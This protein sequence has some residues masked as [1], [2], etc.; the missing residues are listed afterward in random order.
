VPLLK[1]G[2]IF[3]EIHWATLVLELIILIIGISVGLQV[4]EWES[5]RKDRL[6][7]TEYMERLQ[8]DFSES[9][10]ALQKEIENLSASIDKMSVGTNLLHKQSLTKQ[11]HLQ[12]FEAAAAS[13]LV[14][15]FGVLFGTVEELKD[16]GNMRLLHSKA[17]RIAL[18]NL[19]QNYQQTIRLTEMRNLLRSQS[20]P[21]LTRQLKPSEENG[22]GWDEEM[23][24]RQ[25]REIYVALSILLANQ[26][27]DLTDTQELADLVAEI[28]GILNRE[29][30]KS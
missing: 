23:T 29:L 6:L 22:L 7:E 5:Q 17:L 10:K 15:S 3:K 28:N 30:T 20:F 13:A 4:N 2:N 14:A 26:S 24:D 12:I 21:V 1:L 25:K 18:A 11:D 27:Y 8:L 9:E 19:Y 16:T